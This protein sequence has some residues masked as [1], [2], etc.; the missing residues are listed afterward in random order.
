ML[1][2][3]WCHRT[4]RKTAIVIF[5]LLALQITLGILNLFWLRPVSLALMHHAVGILLLLSL[6][7][8]LAKTISPLQDK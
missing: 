3:F 6:I 7:A 5:A 1:I 2:V 4:L 8:T